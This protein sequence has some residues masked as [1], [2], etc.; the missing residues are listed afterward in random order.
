MKA[1]IDVSDAYPFRFWCA[2]NFEVKY[3]KFALQ[4]D[5]ADGLNGEIEIFE[6]KDD[7]EAFWKRKSKRAYR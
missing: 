2:W 4:I 3:K 1:S 5:Y 7:F 6:F